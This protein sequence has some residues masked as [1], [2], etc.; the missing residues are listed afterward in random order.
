VDN[1]QYAELFLTKSREHIAG[2]NKALLELERD[3]SG[4]G[5][6]AAVASIF[7][8][9][10]T[11]KGMGATMGYAIV[12]E[13]AHELET[14]LDR[15]RRGDLAIDA[16][17]MDVL[18]RAIDVLE[19]AVEAAV[20]GRDGEVVATELVATLHAFGVAAPRRSSGG[21][22]I[23]APT[24]AGT[25]IRVRLAPDTPLRG[26]RA[27]IIVKTLR[28]LGEVTNTQP[29]L[30][31]IEVD[32]FDTD[33]AVRLVTTSP[34]AEIERVIRKAGDVVFVRVD[35]PAR[36]S[37]PRPAAVTIEASTSAAP[38]PAADTRS[39]VGQARHVRI[40]VRRLD[41]LMNLIGE[42]LIAR[43][44]LAQLAGELGDQT[45]E[46]TVTQSSR[47][48]GELRDEIT[49]SRMVPVSHIFDR[50]PRVVRDAARAVGKQVD[51]VVD[52]KG[53]ELDRSMLDE[54]GDSIVHLLRNAVDH[55]IETPEART[56][57][58]KAPTGRLVLSAARDR[59]AVVIKV[60]D[61]GKGIDR[62]RVLARAKRD[63]LVDANRTDL[64]EDELLRLLARPGFSTV[65]KVTDLSGRG[66]GVDAVYTRVRALGGAMDIRSVPGQGTTM[67]LRLPLTLAIVRA[68]LVRVA[69]EVYAIP[70]AHVSETIELESDI[71]RTVKGREVLLARDEVLPLMRLRDLVGLPA[72]RAPSEIAL[73]HVV[74]IDL[75]D[76]R[77]GLVIDELTGQEEIVVKQ[78]DAVREGLPFFGGATLLSDGTPS[79]IVDVSSLL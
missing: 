16:A 19:K 54:I 39:V 12:A 15:V 77:A 21:W 28:T 11:I 56:A 40:D 71:L 64:T 67:I 47:L 46:E 41:T 32:G 6:A 53:I 18:F 27:F 70:L 2:V 30:D 79:L 62:E 59:S 50:F 42:L 38:A 61:D 5:A 66:V 44:R 63:G 76:R 29:S 75:G 22:S 65:D 68:L 33:F 34:A 9:V 4:P 52:G 69:D 55:G 17:I 31:D 78:Y 73:E 25:L 35:E 26:V 23:P 14:V 3:V 49:A 10:H 74:V 37:G 7:R 1:L 36:L 45:L 58:G 24:G 48:I 60:S 20:A 72:Y 57:A 43:G 13:L 8:A 51:F